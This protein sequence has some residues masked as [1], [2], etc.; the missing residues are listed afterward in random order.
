MSA[1]ETDED[2][3]GEESVKIMAAAA[4][5]GGDM[6]CEVLDQDIECHTSSNKMMRRRRVIYW[7]YY[8]LWQLAISINLITFTTSSFLSFIVPGRTTLCRTMSIM[9]NMPKM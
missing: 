8:L 4:L 6:P 2:C 5:S 7:L 1:L 3:R 9:R